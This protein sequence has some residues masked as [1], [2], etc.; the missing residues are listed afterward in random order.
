MDLDTDMVRD[1]ADDALAVGG[2]QGL[3]SVGQAGPHP[4]DPESSVRIEHDLDD[5]GFFQPGG[6]GR[7]ERRAQH[8]GAPADGF[9]SERLDAHVRPSNG[10]AGVRPAVGDD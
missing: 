2:R 8:P 10:P 7:A 9:G 4:V 1:Q 3:A 6:D 5:G